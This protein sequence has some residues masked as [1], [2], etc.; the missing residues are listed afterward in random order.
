LSMVEGSVYEL[1]KSEM[2]WNRRN[3][4]NQRNQGNSV[5]KPLLRNQWNLRNH[6]TKC[7]HNTVE[8]RDYAPLFC[9]L[10][11]GKVRRGLILKLDRDISD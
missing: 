10:A 1:L 9:M 6:Y 3:Q 11:L 4:E 5:K 2:Y 8:S 7:V